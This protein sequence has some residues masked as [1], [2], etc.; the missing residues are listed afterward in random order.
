MNA[1]AN[2]TRGRP[3]VFLASVALIWVA[4]RAIALQMPES[5]AAPE[6]PAPEQLAAAPSPEA[7]V[8]AP[9]AAGPTSEELAAAETLVEGLEPVPGAHEHS[10][11]IDSSVAAG[12]D[13]L[14]M[15]ASQD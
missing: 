7:A 14:W 2:P 11:F 5:P 1:R 12:H 15:S 6:A 9:F 10:L 13:M 8:D 3:L 4:V